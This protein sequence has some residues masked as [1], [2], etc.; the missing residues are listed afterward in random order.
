MEELENCEAEL[1][2]QHELLSRPEVYSDSEKARETSQNISRLE[3]KIKNL[4][5][6]WEKAAGELDK[7][8][9]IEG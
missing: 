4:N 8:P 7:L 5:S 2:K 9:V 3:E 6:R 1:A